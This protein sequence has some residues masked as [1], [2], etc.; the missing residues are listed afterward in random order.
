MESWT[1]DS[2]AAERMQTGERI[3]G[4]K[5]KKLDLENERL[6]LMMDFNEIHYKLLTAIE[7][8]SDVRSR[9]L[10]SD[11]DRKEL[12]LEHRVRID[13]K[14]I[15]LRKKLNQLQYEIDKIQIEIDFLEDRREVLV[16]IFAYFPSKEPPV[17]E[18]GE[19]I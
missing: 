12:E 7:N 15:E 2:T 11:D 9:E 19:N 18:T 1:R 4:M 5:L 6:P 17:K 13:P 14:V 16:D 3:K 8:V 10:F